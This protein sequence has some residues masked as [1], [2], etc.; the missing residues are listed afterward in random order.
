MLKT[1]LKKESL[2]TEIDLLENQIRQKRIELRNST[3]TLNEDFDS[4]LSTNRLNFSVD[5]PPTVNSNNNNHLNNQTNTCNYQNCSLNNNGDQTI[6]NPYSYEEVNQDISSLKFEK[7][8]LKKFCLPENSA[9]YAKCAFFL[10]IL[11][12]LKPR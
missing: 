11:R 4:A 6:K 8:S 3:T 9:F 10:R 12:V 1:Q 7:F 5:A 2:I